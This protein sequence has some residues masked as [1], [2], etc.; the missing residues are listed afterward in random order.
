MLLF[1]ISYS[2]LSILPLLSQSDSFSNLLVDSETIT[3]KP[4]CHRAMQAGSLRLPPVSLRCH[5]RQTTRRTQAVPT[6]QTVH[7]KDMCSSIDDLIIIE[8]KRFAEQ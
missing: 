4:Q 7:T 1:P 8:A 5:A 3:A 2:F 6:L